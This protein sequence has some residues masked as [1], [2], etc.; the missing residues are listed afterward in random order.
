MC[1]CRA[2][3]IRFQGDPVPGADHYIFR[4]KIIGVDTKYR[5]PGSS[6]NPDYITEGLPVS[7]TVEVQVVAANAEGTQGP[8]GDSDSVVV[9]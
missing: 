2:G 7:K 5:Y 6:S 3:Q 9:T 4:G 1:K 8:A